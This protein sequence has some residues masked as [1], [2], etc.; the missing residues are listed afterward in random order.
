VVTILEDTIVSNARFVGSSISSSSATIVSTTID[1]NNQNSSVT[2]QDG[3]SSTDLY[4]IVSSLVFAAIMLVLVALSIRKCVRSTNKN[5]KMEHHAAGANLDENFT[6]VSAFEENAAMFSAHAGSYDNATYNRTVAPE[7]VE[8]ALPG[9]V[10]LELDVDFNLGAAIGKGG[11]G[12][13]YQIQPRSSY[14]VKLYV[15][16]VAKVVAPSHTSMQQYQLDCFHQEVSIMKH[17]G[18][19]RNTVELLGWT[20]TPAAIIMKEYTLGSLAGFLSNHPAMIKSMSFHFLADIVSGVSYMHERGIAHCDLKPGNVLIEMD[21][22]YKHICVLTD[23]GIS[24]IHSSNADLVEAF[25]CINM[26]GVSVS[27][28]APEAIDN[29]RRKVPRDKEAVFAGDVY[30]LSMISY[31]IFSGHKPWKF[32][33]VTA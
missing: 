3:I 21:A 18:R 33:P 25:N 24:Q 23:F 14:L 4:I 30:S 15:P 13:I 32:Q 29:F 12:E 7:E 22:Y 28:A 31:E 26:R 9:S 19:S 6:A 1:A 5:R 2:A 10:L 17:L 11:A 16:L 20:E 8:F 27:Y